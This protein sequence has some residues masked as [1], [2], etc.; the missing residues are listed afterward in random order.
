MN[1]IYFVMEGSIKRF[2]YLRKALNIFEKGSNKQMLM[3]RN[4]I[5]NTIEFLKIHHK[6]D[7]DNVNPLHSAEKAYLEIQRGNNESAIEILQELKEMNGELSA[8][9]IYYLGLAKNDRKLLSESLGI[10][11]RLGNIFLCPIA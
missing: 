9:Q 5:Y 2:F 11:E 1:P 8:F 10:F 7:L 3:R 4:M 6:V